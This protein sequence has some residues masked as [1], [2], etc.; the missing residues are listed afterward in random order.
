M[1]Q[2]RYAVDIV[3]TDKMILKK[4]LLIVFLCPVDI[5]TEEG[6]PKIIV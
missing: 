5:T 1:L 4:P 3:A 2:A 6:H